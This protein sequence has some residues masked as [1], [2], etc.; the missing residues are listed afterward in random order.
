M[1]RQKCDHVEFTSLHRCMPNNTHN[2]RIQPCANTYAHHH[3]H[4]AGSIIKT[5]KIQLLRIGLV[6]DQPGAY[7]YDCVDSNTYCKLKTETIFIQIEIKKFL[8]HILI[9]IEPFESHD[10][11]WWE[12]ASCYVQNTTLHNKNYP[13]Y[14]YMCVV[15][16]TST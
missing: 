4:L 10:M 8:N 11:V 1:V 15:A 6:G 12:V 5:V 7:V 2:Q 13:S 14:T 3:T 16:L 9:L